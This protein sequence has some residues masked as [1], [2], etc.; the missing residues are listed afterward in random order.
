MR[1]YL[2]IEPHFELWKY[3]FAVELQKKKEKKKP[4]LAVPMGCTSIHLR[5]SRVSEYMSIPLSKS[6]KG[7]HKLWFYLKNNTAAPLPIFTGRLLEEVPEVWR[8]GAIEKEQKR[9]GS[10]LKAIVTLKRHGLRVTGVIGSY[11]VRRVASLM[12]CAL[13][14]YKMTPDSTPEGTVMVVDVALSIG[15]MT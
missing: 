2:G 3:F 12:A 9:L 15:K 4:D 11:H 8:Y 6:N 13:P 14:M 1:G 7:W 10:L 5:G